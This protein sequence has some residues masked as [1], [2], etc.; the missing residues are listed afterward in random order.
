MS[1]GDVTSYFT[2]YFTDNQAEIVGTTLR[3]AGVIFAAFLLTRLLRR[4]VSKVKTKV[5]AHTTPMRTLQRT[6]TLTRVLSSAGI[7]VIWILVLFLIIE[8]LGFNLAPLLAGVGIIGLAVGFGAQNLV[9]DVVTGF[10]ILFEDQ[11]GVGDIIEINETA[12]GTV[13]ELTLRI[14]GL[15]AL[16]GTLHY[17]SNGNITHVANRSKDWARA[18]VDVGVAYS[19]KPSK[20]RQVLDDVARDAKDDETIGRMLYSVPTIMGVESLGEY[21]VV[22]RLLADTKPG[23]QWEVARMLRERIQIAFEREGIEIPFPHRVMISAGTPGDPR[24]SA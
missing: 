2:S 7:V 15:R 9:R 3:V 20:I 1:L 14:T 19:E 23:R 17:I 16:D 13:E 22:W 5:E 10:F 8:D 12:A 4:I 21:E 6:D 18:I 24:P 11:Y